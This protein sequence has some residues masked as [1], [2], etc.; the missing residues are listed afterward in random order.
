MIPLNEA[1]YRLTGLP[2]SNLKIKERGLLEEGYFADVVIFDPET[3]EDMAT[4][5][6]PHQFANGVI[7]VFVNGVQVLREGDH[8]NEFP[9]VV[10]RWPGWNLK[11]N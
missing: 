8:T 11:T 9:G 5:S 2:A 7:H 6:D 10:V 4:F 3:I 1:I